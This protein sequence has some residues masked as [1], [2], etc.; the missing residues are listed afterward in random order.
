MEKPVEKSFSPENTHFVAAKLGRRLSNIFVVILLLLTLY[1]VGIIL[2]AIPS[3]GFGLLIYQ[4]PVLESL[5]IEEGIFSSTVGVLLQNVLAFASIYLLLWAWLKFYEKR[6]FSSLGLKI[7]SS[8]VGQHLRGILVAL[9][10]IGAWVAIQAASGHLSFEGWMD[11]GPVQLAGFAT[12]LLATYL[13][14][15]FQIGIEEALFRGWALQMIGVRYGAVAGILLSSVFFSFFHFFHIMT[16]FGIGELHDPWPPVLAVNIFLW[17]VFRGPVGSLRGIFV[18]RHSLPRCR[19]V[20]LRL[21][22][23]VR[24]LAKPPRLALGRS[25]LPHRRGR[26]RCSVRRPT[27]DR[28]VRARNP[29]SS[30]TS[31][32]EVQAGSRGLILVELVEYGRV[33]VPTFRSR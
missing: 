15:A 31:A 30:A 26:S 5:F 1:D 16:L 2:G 4:V 20:V 27:G 13:G 28:S 12:I 33:R 32:Q 18:G 19:P 17:A 8:A 22:L 9:V 11:L 29:C 23:R 3:G 24:R 10:M 7:N 14:R 21:R 6:P 25:E